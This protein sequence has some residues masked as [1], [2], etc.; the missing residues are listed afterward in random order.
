MDN[1]RLSLLFGTGNL[2]YLTCHILLNESALAVLIKQCHSLGREQKIDIG[3][4]IFR[5]PLGSTISCRNWVL[6]HEMLSYNG[7]SNLWYP[8]LAIASAVI[9]LY[10]QSVLLNFKATVNIDAINAWTCPSVSVPSS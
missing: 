4:Y 7:T 5:S 3:N 1:D 9:H 6:L 10:Q 2:A 8:Q